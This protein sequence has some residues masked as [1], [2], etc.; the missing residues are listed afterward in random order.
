M[1]SIDLIEREERRQ[2]TDRNQNKQSTEMNY[3]IAAL[4]IKTQHRESL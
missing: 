4:V 1:Q 2:S 3:A